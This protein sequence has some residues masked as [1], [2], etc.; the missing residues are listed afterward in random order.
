ME[1][2]TVSLLN[3]LSYGLLLF[4]LSSG[5][6]LIFSMMGVLNFAHASFYML[7]AYLGYSIGRVTGFWVALLL[8]PLAVGALGA[9]LAG[10]EFSR[11]IAGKT[12]M[13]IVLVPAG[14]ILVGGLTGVVAGPFIAGM[15]YWIGNAIN[16]ATTLRPIPMGI[17]VSVMMG[18]ALTLPISS[19]AL[20]ISLGLS[21]L[22]A[23]A[24]TTGCCCQMIGFAVASYRDNGVGGLFSQGLGTSMIQIP[25]I[26]R[27]PWIW[28]PPTL[29]SAVLG[30]VS[31]VFFRMEN[32]R[33]GAGMGT[34]GLVGQVSTL[35]TMGAAAWPG[36]L[37]LHFLL[38]A[39]LSLLFAEILRKTGRIRPGD[40]KLEK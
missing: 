16:V 8:A 9:S 26:I 14:T 35:E 38:P 31:T 1:F 19:A 29:A 18:V 39:A 12:G 4:M 2:I 40:M 33:V 30:P 32:S 13:D 23:G 27:N 5:L 15:M 34:S 6:T 37:L 28:I 22:A 20:A 24:S 11:R 25:N 17:L 10:A 21:G 7:G 36:I 3:G